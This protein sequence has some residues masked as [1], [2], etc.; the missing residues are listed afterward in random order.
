MVDP[1]PQSIVVHWFHGWFAQVI[2]NVVVEAEVKEGSVVDVI[3]GFRT[4]VLV[5]SDEEVTIDVVLIQYGVC[6]LHHLQGGELFPCQ[7]P[8]VP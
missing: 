6:P 7:Y 4:V 5:G 1:S 2:R 8:G 3:V